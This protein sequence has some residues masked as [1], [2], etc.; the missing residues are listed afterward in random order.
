MLSLIK[1]I[2]NVFEICVKAR[3]D[4][5]FEKTKKGYNFARNCKN[6]NSLG[7][8]Q[9]GCSL[10]LP[11][12]IN[13]WQVRWQDFADEQTENKGKKCPFSMWKT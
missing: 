13:I 6:K 4:F 8:A 10:L 5:N 9:Q 7:Y 2:W 1:I 12:V 3:H 11:S